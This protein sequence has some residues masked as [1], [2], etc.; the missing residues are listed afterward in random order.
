MNNLIH[1]FIKCGYAI[2]E[3]DDV[4]AQL[5]SECLQNWHEFLLSDEI[6]Q[7]L[8]N[9]ETHFGFIPDF[10][11]HLNYSGMKETNDFKNPV[12]HSRYFDFSYKPLDELLQQRKNNGFIFSCFHWYNWAL[13][14]NRTFAKTHLLFQ[15]LLVKAEEFLHAIAPYVNNYPCPEIDEYKT[16]FRALYYQRQIGANILAEPHSDINLITLIPLAAAPALQI[17]DKDTWHS[18]PQRS[19]KLLVLAGDM[20][21]FISNGMIP[22]ATH[23]VCFSDENISERI[24]LPFF[25]HPKEDLQLRQ[26]LLAANYYQARMRDFN[27]MQASTKITTE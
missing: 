21:Q 5:I 7:H 6:F 20:M 11:S 8:F 4:E 13:P 15:K 3:L 24:S 16:Q 27:V 25:V 12:K 22:A 26:S 19:D 2:L 14:V 23:K 18:I 10:I 1:S 17:L 9:V